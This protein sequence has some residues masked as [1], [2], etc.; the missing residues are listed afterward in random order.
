MNEDKSKFVEYHVPCSK[1]GSSDARSVND[2]G[3][4][5]CFSCTTFF[6]NETGINQQYERGDMQTAEKITNLSY[7]QGTLSAISDRGIS[8]LNSKMSPTDEVAQYVFANNT[9]RVVGSP[10]MWQGRASE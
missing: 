9:R 3:S 8:S 10:V 7:H 5:Y 1:C 2:D 6:P 4:S